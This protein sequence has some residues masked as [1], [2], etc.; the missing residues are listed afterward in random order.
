[1]NWRGII[2]LGV[3]LLLAAACYGAL[4]VQSLLQKSLTLDETVYIPVGS[5]LVENGDWTVNPEQPPLPKILAGVA[6]RGLN[7]EIP[8]PFD[9][10]GFLRANKE[11][12][13]RWTTRARIAAV[14]VGVL[15]LLGVF[16]LAT[17]I[18]SVWAGLLAVVLAAFSP[19]L[20]A[21]GRLVT[22]DLP[23]ACFL[24]WTGFF[25]V[26][27]TDRFHPADL[28]GL[29]VAFGLAAASKFTALLALPLLLVAGWVMSLIPEEETKPWR[30]S[31]ASWPV[32]IMYPPFLVVAMVI[33][34]APVVWG[35][36]GF[37][38]GPVAPLLDA[39]LAES[40]GLSPEAQSRIAAAD[41][42]EDAPAPWRLRARLP[43]PS[44]WHG[45]L[46]LRERGEGEYAY[47]RGRISYEGWWNYYP[48]CFLVKTPLPI[49]IALILWVGMAVLK[50]LPVGRGEALCLLV[51]VGTIVFFSTQRVDL[52]Y[53]YLLPAVP[54][55]LVLL[56]GLAGGL[57]ERGKMWIAGVVMLAGLQVGA[58]QSIHPHYLA[59]FNA[60][61]GG[62]E[63]GRHW[64]VDSNLDWGQD[65]LGLSRFVRDTGIRDLKF[66]TSGNV[67][68][69]Y[70]GLSYY[71][72]ASPFFVRSQDR[73][74]ARRCSPVHGWVAV[75]ATN[76]AG[77]HLDPEDCYRWLEDRDPVATVGHSILI[78]Y[79][80]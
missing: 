30:S 4:A 57:P 16:A 40:L 67:N 29:G 55:L 44:F 49:L 53:R 36:Y 10:G 62:P 64:L 6:N 54:F 13:V 20:L 76:L 39:E 48:I 31:P 59:Y 42:T 69:E 21:H 22:G 15:T 56:G 75:G 17:Q 66:S 5:H 19:N 34:A 60:L 8:E 71:Y 9:V 25:F 37:Q 28:A 78:Y 38:R 24:V 12:I 72:L 77:V 14:L 47:L 1:M 2:I 3:V 43:A 74:R 68:P 26:R 52:G 80:E 46:K 70:Y 58:A 79:L 65:V 61:A 50:V 32:R 23:L 73:H 33:V 7:L 45:I 41:S 18:R 63:G 35:L 51:V 11:S 27:L